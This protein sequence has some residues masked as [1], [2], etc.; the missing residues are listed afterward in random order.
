LG[1]AFPFLECGPRRGRDPREK[2]DARGG[3][4]VAEDARSRP[5]RVLESGLRIAL[6]D[7]PA[8]E[9][10]VVSEILLEEAG[11]RQVAAA[12]PRAEFLDDGE[13]PFDVG[14][15]R[16]PSAFVAKKTGP[17]RV[18]LRL[19]LGR[20]RACRENASGPIEQSDRVAAR[21]HISR[22]TRAR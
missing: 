13:R 15:R 7:E 19:V 3:E 17:R 21:A 2:I 18:R 11:T 12:T 10:V 1:A 14:A 6:L 22:A 4:V 20:G 16:I 9:R 8:D 5:L